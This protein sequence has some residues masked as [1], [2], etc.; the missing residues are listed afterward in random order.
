MSRRVV[1]LVKRQPE[2]VWPILAE[3]IKPAETLVKMRAGSLLMGVEFRDGERYP[4][5]LTLDQAVDVVAWAG[6][7]L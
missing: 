7:I 4:P 1:S 3:P 2:R 5:P 6:P